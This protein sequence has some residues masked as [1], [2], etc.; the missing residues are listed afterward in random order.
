MSV[1]ICS[2]MKSLYCF[3]NFSKECPNIRVKDQ[4][5]QNNFEL[6]PNPRLAKVAHQLYEGVFSE[7]S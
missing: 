2:S 1:F 3:K 6:A 4:K 5:N 7:M